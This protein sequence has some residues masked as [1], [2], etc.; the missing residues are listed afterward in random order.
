MPYRPLTMSDKT[1]GPG[2]DTSILTKTKTKTQRPPLYKVLLLN[3]TGIHRRLIFQVYAL[4]LYLVRPSA[5]EK[6]IL[7]TRDTKL[8]FELLRCQG[9]AAATSIDEMNVVI[10]AEHQARHQSFI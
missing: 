1:D 7:A 8:L 10:E 6:E 2:N 3:G 5:D 9:I 4:S